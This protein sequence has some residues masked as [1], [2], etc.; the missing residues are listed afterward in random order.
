MILDLRHGVI[1][2]DPAPKVGE[3]EILTAS[4]VDGDGHYKPA[5]CARLYLSERDRYALARALLKDLP[6]ENECP[7]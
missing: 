4:R 2:F 5:E 3:I 1:R 6:P 7:L